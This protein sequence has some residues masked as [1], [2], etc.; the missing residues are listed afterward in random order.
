MGFKLFEFC[1]T[2]YLSKFV[3]NQRVIPKVEFALKFTY[4]NI[5]KYYVL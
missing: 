2:V 1:D 3:K 4:L 5:L